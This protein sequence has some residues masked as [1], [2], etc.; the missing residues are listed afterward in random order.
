MDVHRGRVPAGID[1][2]ER[3]DAA[4]VRHLDA[5]RGHFVV[6]LDADALA[7]QCQTSTAASLIGA[8]ESASA[9]VTRRASGTPAGP[10]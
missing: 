6:T 3:R 8:Q 4:R 1:G 9:T 10:R 5:A 2:L 7:S